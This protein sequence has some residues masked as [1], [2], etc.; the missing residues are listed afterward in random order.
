[1]TVVLINSFTVDPA[2][3]EEFL[4]TWRATIGHF[5]AAPGFLEARLHRNTGLNDTTFQ[6]VNVARWA[7]ADAYHAAFRDF[8]PAGQRV[9]GVRAY[10]GL[11]E[12]VAE[13]RPDGS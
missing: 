2:H 6:Y 10:P 5:T 4:A 7:S 13:V 1:M 11:F 9:A 12:V 3:D 8:T